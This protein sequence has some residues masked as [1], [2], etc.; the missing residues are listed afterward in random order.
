LGKAVSNEKPPLFNNQITSTKSPALL[1]KQIRSLLSD[2]A[3]YIGP[4]SKSIL[5][6]PVVNC[7]GHTF[8]RDCIS[9]WFET[10]LMCPLSGRMCVSIKL[11][12]NHSLR[13][14]IMAYKE[15]KSKRIQRFF[16]ENTDAFL[17]Q[18]FLIE[19]SQM[20]VDLLKKWLMFCGCVRPEDDDDSLHASPAPAPSTSS[21]RAV[22]REAFEILDQFDRTLSAKEIHPHRIMYQCELL[23][24]EQAFTEARHLL[25]RL[26]GFDLLNDRRMILSESRTRMAVRSTS[27]FSNLASRKEAVFHIRRKVCV[28]LLKIYEQEQEERQKFH[29]ALKMA[30]LLSDNLHLVKLVD[31]YPLE[32]LGI[33]CS[34]SDYCHFLETIEGI[35]FYLYGGTVDMHRFWNRMCDT[36]NEANRFQ[37]QLAVVNKMI[38]Q[39][40][41][42]LESDES[43]RIYMSIAFCSAAILTIRLNPVTPTEELVHNLHMAQHYNAENNVAKRLLNSLEKGERLFVSRDEDE[44]SISNRFAL[45]DEQH[46]SDDTTSMRAPI[47]P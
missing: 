16:R 9:R 14:L 21:H 45:H 11:I 44:S 31:Y 7:F 46:S 39:R 23:I 38:A 8:E 27:D 47:S 22:Q 36:Y 1:D 2:P 19:H 6:E 5:S 43:Y 33:S 4:I 40:V 3:E 15:S 30:R 34:W 41:Q 24:R 26:D 17:D 10:S 37:E 35:H 13:T 12:P 28:M 20:L 29:T 25:E 18:S 32:F 42:E